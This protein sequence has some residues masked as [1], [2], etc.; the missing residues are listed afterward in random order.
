MLMINYYFVVFTRV[1]FT[2]VSVV[3]AGGD[4]RHSILLQHFGHNRTCFSCIQD[5]FSRILLITE[6]VRFISTHTHT[7]THTA[8]SHYAFP[9]NICVKIYIL[10]VL[11]KA[12]RYINIRG[13]CDDSFMTLDLKQNNN[14]EDQ[15]KKQL[16]TIG[17][18]N[19]NVPRAPL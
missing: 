4:T 6:P 14:L 16:Q 19:N 17:L 1:I 10:N 12:T 2:K 13:E 5:M 18:S 9:E 7:H 15:T 3:T 11:I 8:L